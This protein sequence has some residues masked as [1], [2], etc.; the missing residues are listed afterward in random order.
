MKTSKKNL[1]HPF[2][3]VLAGATG[4]V[5]TELLRQLSLHPHVSEIRMIGR[6]APDSYPEK[7]LFFSSGFDNL[8]AH[9][10][11][12][13]ETRAVFCALG[14]TI[15]KAGNQENFR[16][17]DYH[18]P[19]AL[20]KTAVKAQINGFGLVSALGA[21]AASSIFYNRVK[22]ELERDIAE[23]GLQ[24]LCIARPS[25]L[26]GNRRE[27]RIGER[28][29]QIFTPIAPAAFKPVHASAVA[30]AL[31]HHVLDSPAAGVTFLENPEI[32]NYS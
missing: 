24:H 4:L 32:L 14:T 19:L 11:W 29:G 20:A 17:V 1:N 28:I 15:K 25:L 2:P 8:D 26:L 30:K 6:S 12:F 16:K 9:P 22:G 31:I 5:G 21:N 3:V 7:A 27:L 18:F 10:E 13:S 23:A